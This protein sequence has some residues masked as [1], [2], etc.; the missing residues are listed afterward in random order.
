MECV[1]VNPDR[2]IMNSEQ[3]SFERLAF[4]KYLASFLCLDKD[5]PSIVVGIDGKWGEGKTSCINL[6]KEILTKNSSR[7]I[8]VDYNP[9]LISTLDSVIEGFFIELASAIGEQST[10]KNAKAAAHKVLQF[11][12][13]LAPIKL[14]PGVEPW[15]TMV[16][17]VLSTVGG[18]AK[19]GAELADL[20]LQTRKI[21]LQKSLSHINRPLVVIIDDIDRL[22]PEHVR[23]VF[24]MLKAVCNFNRVSYL[25]A[26]DSQQVKDALSGA[27]RG[28]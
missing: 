28:R 24:Q 12:K 11:G 18:A 22:S 9:W 27:S 3:D 10:A 15:G 2:P 13:M 25:I 7:P 19:A 1:S 5:E 4:A 20:S 23:I 17:S 26:Y 21:D 6:I 16:E 8:I 14:I